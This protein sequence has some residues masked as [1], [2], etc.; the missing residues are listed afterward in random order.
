MYMRVCGH[1]FTVEFIH[2]ALAIYSQSDMKVH[3]WRAFWEFRLKGPV[4]AG[5]MFSPWVAAEDA[6]V[7]GDY[8]KLKGLLQAMVAR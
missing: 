6:A 1:K 5:N 4:P 2:V 8:D 7:Q 3:H